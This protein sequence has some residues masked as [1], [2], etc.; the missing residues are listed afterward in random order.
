MVLLPVCY[1]K[2]SKNLNALSTGSITGQWNSKK[3]TVNIL[4]ANCKYFDPIEN[5]GVF[6]S[7]SGSFARQ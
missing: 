3:M 1:V 6:P 5:Q 4:Y 2:C 7:L